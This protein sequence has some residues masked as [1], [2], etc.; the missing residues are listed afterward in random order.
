SDDNTLLV[1]LADFTD[2]NT[3][4]VTIPDA[5]KDVGNFSHMDANSFVGLLGQ[6][7]G[8]LDQFR[9]S[10]T[11]ANFDV[12]LLGPALDKQLAVS[13]AFRNALLIDEG[14]DGAIDTGDKVDTVLTNALH[15][16]GLEMHA[17]ISNGHV[18]LLV[19]DFSG[20]PFVLDGAGALGFGASVTPTNLTA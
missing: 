7:T 5:I 14:A 4:T 12:P 16:A 18:R 2:F 11:F 10:G 1:S 20:I 8:A 13:D 6:A 9:H 15:A 3:A 19:D 17:E